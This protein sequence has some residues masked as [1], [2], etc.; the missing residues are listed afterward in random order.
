MAGRGKSSGP[1][2]YPSRLDKNASFSDAVIYYMKEKGYSQ[3]ELARLTYL[4]EM[5][6]SRI[7]RDTNGRGGRYEPTMQVV[8][9]LWIG[10]QLGPEEAKDLLLRAFPELPLFREI[11]TQKMD[12]GCANDLLADHGFPCLGDR[13]QRN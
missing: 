5:T 4:S 6:V 9:A 1:Q 11:L 2:R 8:E 13:Y 12:I 10:L 7:C 3:G